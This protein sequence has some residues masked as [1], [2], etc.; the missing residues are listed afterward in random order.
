MGIDQTTARN[1][2]E[3]ALSNKKEKNQKIKE[4]KRKREREG[5]ERERE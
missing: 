1:R 5:G 4:E 2:R 3:N